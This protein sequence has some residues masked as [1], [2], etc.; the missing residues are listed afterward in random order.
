[1]PSHIGFEACALLFVDS[2]D[3]A[4]EGAKHGLALNAPLSTNGC[5]QCG[6]AKVDTVYGTTYAP[7]LC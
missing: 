3:Y 2:V 5:G 4:I 7:V 1:M 6:Q